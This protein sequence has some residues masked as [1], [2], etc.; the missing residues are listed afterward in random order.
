[1]E[2]KT[3]TTSGFK[4]VETREELIYLLSRASELEHG[5]A[6][7]Y[8]FA[9]Y[10]LKSD[11]GEGGM[12][13]AHAAM[14][15]TWK[16]QVAGVAVEEMLHLAQ[17][18]NML[19]AIG[20][21]PNFR[22]TNFPLPE[23]A[24][25]FGIS[26]R[27]EP[28]SLSTIE[29]F[30]VYEIPEEG[31]LSAEKHVVYADLR[32][33]VI[34]FQETTFKTLTPQELEPEAELVARFGKE[35]FKYQEPFEID[36]KTVGEF[37]H[38]IKSGFEHIP[39]DILFIGPQEAQANARFVD[40]GGELVAVNNRLSASDAI[41]MIVE[42]GEAPTAIHPDCH[43]MIFDNIRLQYIAAM[44]EAGKSDIPFEPVRNTASNPMTRFYDDTSGG[45]LLLD[46]LTHTAADIF[47]VSY[48]TMLQMLLRFF[49]HTDESEDEL[50]MLSKA[51]LR[52]MTTVIRPL[53]NALTKMP[54]GDPRNPGLMAGPGF[55]YNRDINLLPHKNSAWVF[56]AER[57]YGLAKEA[58]ELA[59]KPNVPK[60]VQEASASLQAISDMFM[61]KTERYK[62]LK[63]GKVFEKE[64]S[65]LFPQIDPELDGPYLVK[66][67]TSLLNS[68]GEALP[69]EP[70]MA[71]CRCGGSKNKPF[72]DGTHA[73]IGF[74]SK[75][76][77]GR[78][79]DRLDDYDGEGY[80]VKDN[81]GICQ[82][83]GF[84]TD[85]LPEVF[86]LGKEP[87]VDQF[88]A[89]TG[90]IALQTLKCPSGAISFSPDNFP[91]IL[92]FE[93]STERPHITV[94]KNGPYRVKGNIRLEAG[95]LQG[96]SQ[97]RFTLCRCGGSKN[98]PFCDGTHWYNNFTDDKN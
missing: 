56:F 93:D 10:S 23:S 60:E 90:R 33:K 37:Y 11:I 95:F 77:P 63:I 52:M 75:K 83:S 3:E 64:E 67:I 32:E 4:P 78:Q 89:E 22:R 41:E 28:F 69:A 35:A 40:L 42:Q 79:P 1:M 48:D 38:K 76:L 51:T 5:L 8:L 97:N 15:K 6:C 62:N 44:E 57:L 46:P 36:F 74:E 71:L 43:F 29:R 58:T 82:H 45:T 96:A 13:E 21:A 87:F 17:V 80:T 34:K 66:G 53:G 98:K 88:A 54:V 26:L 91:V 2:K 70:Q 27:L 14:V 9:A 73:A 94:S 65:F 16:R 24:F 19:T 61:H 50:E 30:V 7:I 72:C 31:V 68:K 39:E 85:Q 25:P 20:G 92:S 86:R 81:R 12:T 18:N 49:A 55:G 84:C 59:A 47:N